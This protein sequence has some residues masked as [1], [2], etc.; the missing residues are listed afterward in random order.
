MPN[1]PAVSALG[2]FLKAFE[3]EKIPCILIDRARR[4]AYDS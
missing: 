1:Q 2:A 4:A 3:E